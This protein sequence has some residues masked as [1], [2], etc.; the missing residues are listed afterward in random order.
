MNKSLP[1]GQNSPDTSGYSVN[2]SF[3]PAGMSLPQSGKR[4][5]E[6][7]PQRAGPPGA[8]KI[9]LLGRNEF[10]LRLVL[11]KSIP[12]GFC[13]TAKPPLHFLA[14]PLPEKAGAFPGTHIRVK[15]LVRATWR[16]GANRVKSV[17]CRDMCA[18]I[19]G[20]PA[21]TRQGSL[22][23]ERRGKGVSAVFPDR[24]KRRKA[25]FAPTTSRPANVQAAPY[26]ASALQRTAT[27]PS[28]KHGPSPELLGEGPCLF[29]RLS[30]PL[31]VPYT[32][33]PGRPPP[34]RRWRR[35]PYPRGGSAGGSTPP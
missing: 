4:L 14:R 5:A 35:R 10:A 32:V 28:E 8:P 33:P 15:T 26:A 21:Q 27:H 34:R 20:A 25:D 11:A 12:L 29:R 23:G 17:F 30:R 24:G 22:R 2:L 9:N 1:S 6:F 3:P 19:Y 31:S 18:A 13:L 7:A 16:G